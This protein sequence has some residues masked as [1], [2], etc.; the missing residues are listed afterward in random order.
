MSGARTCEV[1]YRCGRESLAAGAGDVC[2]ESGH[3][4]DVVRK[5]LSSVLG[6][7]SS[8]L[9]GDDVAW[10]VCTHSNSTHV[11]RATEQNDTLAGDVGDVMCA[12]R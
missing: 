6:C 8:H 11:M 7:F 3:W 12:V 5:Y 4:T 9:R 1:T 10:Y 2:H